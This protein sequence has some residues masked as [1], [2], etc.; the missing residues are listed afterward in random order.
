MRSS[1]SARRPRRGVTA[2]EILIALGIFALVSIF[3]WRALGM[4]LEGSRKAEWRTSAERNLESV[5]HFLREELARANHLLARTPGSGGE[6]HL[7]RFSAVWLSE[8][9][10]AVRFRCFEPDQEVAG[11]PAEMDPDEFDQDQVFVGVREK[12]LVL[13]RRGVLEGDLTRTLLQKVSVL[14]FEAES[15][16][17]RHGVTRGVLKLTAEIRD[18]KS[19]QFLRRSWTFSLAVPVFDEARPPQMQFVPAP[20]IARPLPEAETSE[21]D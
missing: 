12:N 9:G 4:A 1:P 2:L 14:Q 13:V 5:A 17:G 19:P 7:P 3:L 15:D 11:D 21:S 8:G 10:Q 20:G 18:P 6:V 16:F